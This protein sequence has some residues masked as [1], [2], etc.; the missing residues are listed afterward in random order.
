MITPDFQDLPVLIDR[1]AH[2]RPSARRVVFLVGA[3]LSAPERQGD[4]GV[5]G[6]AGMIDLIR[7]EIGP[8]NTERFNA[9]IATRANFYQAAF[10]QLIAYRGQDK[11]NEIVRRAV[12]QARTSP[13][14]IARSLYGEL[15]LEVLGALENSADGWKLPIGVRSLGK[16]IAAHANTF[17]RAVLTSNFDPL[18]EV[19]IRRSGGQYYRTVLHRDGDLSQSSADGCHVVHF[20]GFWI[21]RD[22]LHTPGQLGQSRPRLRQSLARLLGSSTVVVLAYGGWDDI[23]TT[24]LL[25][26]VLDDDAKPDILWTF[27]ESINPLS[28]DTNRRLVER[29]EPGIARGRITLFKGIDCNTFLPRL[30]Q[31]L[32]DERPGNAIQLGGNVST[33]VVEVT[34]PGTREARLELRITIPDDGAFEP[35]TDS[36]PQ[37]D[38]W[39][40]RAA[41]THLLEA[42]TTPAAVIT[43]I[44]GQGK[45]ALAAHYL[46][47][48]YKTSF[49]EWDWRDCREESDRINTQLIR[50]IFRLSAG[51]IDPSTLDSLDLRSLIETFFDAL[52]DRR[53]LFVFDNVDHYVDLV[54]G[55]FVAGVGQLFDAV[56]ARQHRSRFL[57]TCR[58]E[59]RSESPRVLHL[60]LRGLSECETTEL[61]RKRGVSDA[62]ID[63]VRD[64]FVLTRGHPMWVNMIAM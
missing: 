47:Q 59:V 64:A 57:F 20:H 45:S 32:T 12:I 53:W 18:I 16:I 63:N 58:P 60:P 51:R 62:E 21:D 46:G 42:N 27:F 11:A 6:T 41:E 54:T 14:D 39:V 52:G 55:E 43:G 24:A 5:P 31:E 61:F 30:L 22:T 3:P 1:L 34:D 9:K 29:L 26:V 13:D 17:G 19:S 38:E 2:V 49:D 40:G 25:D 15:D 28:N 35:D 4:R 56:V 37:I 44:G 7:Q 48:Q 36:P 8:E 33:R 23:L 10:E 50:I